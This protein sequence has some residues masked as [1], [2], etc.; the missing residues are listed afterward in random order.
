VMEIGLPILFAIFLWWFS[1]GAILYLDGRP[2]RTF[3]VSMAAASLIALLALLAIWWTRSDSTTASAYI[4]FTAALLLWGWNEMAFLMGYITGTRRIPANPRSTGWQR[5]I[6]AAQTIITHEIAIAITG[7]AIAILCW[8][9]ANMVA[10]WTFL[11]LWMMRL[12]TK[13]N[14]FLGAPNVADEFL[15]PHLA[16]LS[17]YFRRRPMNGFFP[18]AISLSTLIT[19]WL[20]H[21]A[22]WAQGAPFEATAY[23]LLACLMAL[24][25]LEHWLL[26]IPLP[27]SWLWRW[28]L[29][30]RAAPMPATVTSKD[31]NAG[32][33][34]R[35]SG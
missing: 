12:S 34:S 29:K 25:V 15:P 5:F 26:F 19:A 33:V 23:S 31:L 22:I 24:A 13:L 11:I 6:E 7:I 2:S 32:G 17:S 18:L 35:R 3:A 4:A 8:N 27:T 10:F 14:I 20:I 28:G 21:K 9:T 16:Y 1:T 30:N